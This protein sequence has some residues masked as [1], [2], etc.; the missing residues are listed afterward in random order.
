[1]NNRVYDMAMDLLLEEPYAMQESYSNEQIA[2]C[3]QKIVGR[4]NRC[5]G[6]YSQTVT[7]DLGLLQIKV[8]NASSRNGGSFVS[9]SD[10]TAATYVSKS[11]AEIIDVS[12]VCTEEEVKGLIEMLDE[13]FFALNDSRI[14]FI[15]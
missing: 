1:M 14:Y 8:K 13:A 6:R 7:A 15:P 2:E 10:E 9:V 11:L 5:P 12:V 3:V 4:L